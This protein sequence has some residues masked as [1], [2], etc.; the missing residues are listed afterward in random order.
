MLRIGT[1]GWNYPHWRGVFYPRELPPR[2]WLQYYSAH[3]DTVEINYSFYRLPARETFAAWQTQVPPGFLFATKGSRFITHLKRLQDPA[4]PVERFFSHLAALG[5]TAGPILWQLPPQ[6]ACDRER[7]AT[8]LAILPRAY[9]HAF[10]FRHDSWYCEPV[11]TL[12]AAYDAALCLADRGG[13]HT[14]L[15]RPATWTY[16]RF[17]G[18][19]GAGWRYL[20]AQLTTWAERIARYRAEG[21]AVY[22]YFN[23]DAYGHAVSDAQRLRALLAG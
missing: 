1:S 21:A 14:P 3:F 17:H 22:A 19:L 13:G 16:I 6:F 7:L 4:E 11:Y 10:E 12:L 18:G 20:D 15:V 9:R 5:P 23:N 8:F 2:R